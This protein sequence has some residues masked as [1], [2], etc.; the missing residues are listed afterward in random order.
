M[1]DIGKAGE[2]RETTSSAFGPVQVTAAE[3]RPFWYE[4]ESAHVGD[5]VV[6]RIASSPCTVRRTSHSAGKARMVKVV[7]QTRG[8]CDFE[9][10]GRQSVLA[11]GH[12]SVFTCERPY[13]FTTREPAEV[14]VAGIPSGRLGSH[15]DVLRRQPTVRSPADSGTG[16][17]VTG[18]FRAM[19]GLLRRDGASLSGS[20]GRH[21]GDALTSLI[22]AQM[23]DA[24]SV[25]TDGD[26]AERIL[27]YCTVHL[28]DPSLS[29][30]SVARAH[31]MSV[32]Y[33]HKLFQDRE[34][35]LAAWIRRRRLEGIKKDLADPALA[36]RTVASVAARWGVQGAPHLSR[37]LRAEF[38]CTAADIRRTTRRAG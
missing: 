18:F 5:V 7:L 11:P 35:S 17:M 31:R 33:L 25:A 2:L 38:G 9:Q 15:V 27:A 36:H 26:P 19:T 34:Q 20:A 1:N 16:Q 3:S 23:V 10:G 30:A 4:F 8:R 21:L 6:A 22:I 28:A 24:P 13:E 14:I 12:L 29:V 37:A 32:R